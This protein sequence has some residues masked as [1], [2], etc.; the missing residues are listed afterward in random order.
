MFGT[1]V[2]SEFVERGFCTEHGGF[3]VAIVTFLGFFL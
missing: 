2:T 1:D 3:F